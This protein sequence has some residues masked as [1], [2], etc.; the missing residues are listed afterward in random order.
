MTFI[1]EK[2]NDFLEIFEASKN[3]ISVCDGC[4]KVE[5]LR[6]TEHPNIFFTH[7]IWENEN[8]LENYRNSELFKTTWA[9][10][11]ILFS[12]KPQA[13]SLKAM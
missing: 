1:P 13:W 2:T 10:T 7:S 5:L 12:E 4:K 3:K 6:D 9:K 11:K 8:A